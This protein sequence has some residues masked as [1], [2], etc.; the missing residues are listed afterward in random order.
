MIEKVLKNRERALVQ[1]EG[2]AK[3]YPSEEILGSMTTVKAFAAFYSKHKTALEVAKCSH[4]I[5]YCNRG[6]FTPEEYSAFN[7]GMETMYKIFEAAEL[8][9][10]SYLLQAE[11]ENRKSV[12]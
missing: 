7:F 9:L 10:N 8:D 5:D 6:G 1:Q 4:L 11:N 12:G 3:V 2:G